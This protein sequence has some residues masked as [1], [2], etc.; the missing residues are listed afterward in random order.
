MEL[1]QKIWTWIDYNRFLVIFLLVALV[2]WFTAASCEPMTESILNPPSQI[3]ADQLKVELV[4]WQKQQEVYVMKFD[5]AGKD[6]ERQKTEMAALQKFIL[7]LA[8]GNFG[9]AQS[10]IIALITGGGLGAIID[11][12]R[13]RSLISG[14]KINTTTSQ[15]P[16]K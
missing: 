9:N 7:D 2:I 10:A 12:I 5:N 8:S 6:I 4:D 16:P 13:K 3:T 14:L 11:N 15:G 1:L